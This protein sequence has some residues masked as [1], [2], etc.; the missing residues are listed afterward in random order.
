M[1][2]ATPII[3][4]LKAAAL[5]VLPAIFVLGPV[6]ARQGQHFQGPEQQ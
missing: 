5:V 6:L 1:R 4:I 3:G 2:A